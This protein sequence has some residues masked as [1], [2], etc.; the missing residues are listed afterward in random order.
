MYCLK[1]S[2]KSPPSNWYHDF[3]KLPHVMNFSEAKEVQEFVDSFSKGKECYTLKEMEQWVRLVAGFH[4]RLP[5]RPYTKRRD[6]KKKYTRL[7]KESEELLK[8][9]CNEPKPLRGLS[10]FHG[11]MCKNYP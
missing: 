2:P 7:K 4:K 10:Y 8:S 1:R 9:F 11:M 3:P 5:L 6:F